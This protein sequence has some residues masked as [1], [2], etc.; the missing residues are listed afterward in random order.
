MSASTDLSVES[1]TIGGAPF[2]SGGEASARIEKLLDTIRN[3]AGPLAWQRVDE[4]LQV[5]MDLYGRGLSRLLELIAPDEATQLALAEDDLVSSLLALH[6]LHPL[7]METRLRRTLDGLKPKL[8][9]ID[10]IALDGGTARLRAVDPPEIADLDRALER[11]VLEV[12]PELDRVLIEGLRKPSRHG[13]LVQIDLA[14]SRTASPA[15]AP[16]DEP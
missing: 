7:S 2:L 12:A 13:P 3:T 10:L 9:A 5:L 6:G 4:L 1:V 14:R 16:K 15:A 8:G 11:M